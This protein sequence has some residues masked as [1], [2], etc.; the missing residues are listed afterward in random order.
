MAGWWFVHVAV[1]RWANFETNA[2]D[3]GF[4]DQIIYNTLHGRVGQTSFISYNFFGQHFEP[5]LFLFVPFYALGANALFLTVTQAVV[6]AASAVPAVA[7]ARRFG[8][9]VWGA[10]AIAAAL[11]LNP[12]LQ[13]GLAFDFHPEV[14]AVLP[15]AFAAWAIA[16]GR[17]RLAVLAALAPLLL[18]EDAGFVS[19]ALAGLMWSRGM[20]REARWAAAIA[21]A[22]MLIVI[23][24]VLPLSRHG[25]PSDLV[26]RYGYLGDGSG[27]SRLVLDVALHPWRV[28]QELLAPETLWTAGLFLAISVPAAILRPRWFIFLGPGLL[29]ALLSAHTAQN[30]LEFHYPAGLVAVAFVVSL[31]ALSRARGPRVR[32]LIPAATLAASV[33]GFV[34]LSPLAPGEAN[35]RAPTE[36]H[37]AALNAGLA[38]IPS[39]AAGDQV[40]VSAQTGLVPRVSQRDEVH[41]FPARWHDSAYVVIDRYGAVSSQSQAFGYAGALVGVNATMDK[42]FDQDGVQVFRRKR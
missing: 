18:K 37:L 11:I 25:A 30:Q 28:F 31:G 16:A 7:A 21:A 36:A 40:R 12:Y 35:N 32:Q 42:L 27:Q 8:A 22:W 13:R 33:L 15:A 4:F 34:F 19:F 17:S 9:P 38:L 6:V 14:M 41:E 39:G 2:F 1:R 23:L 20:R 26:E 5:G 29:V 3:L 10:L 24:V